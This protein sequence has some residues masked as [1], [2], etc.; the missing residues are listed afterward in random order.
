MMDKALIDS[1][2]ANVKA[3]ADRYWA[4]IWLE[5]RCTTLWHECVFR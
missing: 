5:E 3:N 4:R 1:I 2:Y